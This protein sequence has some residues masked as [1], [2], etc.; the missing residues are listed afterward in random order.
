MKKKVGIVCTKTEQ[1][2][3]NS[4]YDPMLREL[5]GNFVSLDAQEPLFTTD[6][7]GL[8]EAYLGAFPDPES[9]QHHTCNACRR[10]VEAYGGLAIIVNGRVEP[11][12]WHSIVHPLYERPVA[13]MAGI[14]RKAKITGVFLTSKP[15]LGTPETGPWHHFALCV[16]SQRL[17]RAGVKTA[18]QA[19]AEKLEDYRNLSRALPEFSLA[20]L[21]AA[22]ALLESRALYRSDKVLGMAKWLLQLKIEQHAFAGKIRNNILWEA[23][24][25]APAGFCHPRSSMIGTLLEDIESGL[26]FED[27]SR[28][29]AEKMSPLQYQRPSADPSEGTIKAATVAFAQL[30]LES[31]LQR[32]HATVDDVTCWLWRPAKEPETKTRGVFDHLSKKNVKETVLRAPATIMTAVKFLETVAPNASAMEVLVPERGPFVALTTAVDPNAKPIIQWDRE[33][34]RNPVSWYLYASGSTARA[35]SL[36]PAGA[37]HPVVGL[38]PLPAHWTQK[39]PNFGPSMVVVIEGAR[40][41]WQPGL[42]LFPEVLM[43]DLK[44]YRGVIEAHSN[45]AK[46]VTIAAPNAAG[47]LFNSSTPA[48]PLRLR[49]RIDSLW[50]SF[51]IDR[52]D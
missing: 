15:V 11:A 37:Y 51:A 27:I 9:R 31:A 36:E 38:T 49:V 46:M 25:K 12:I 17:Y 33:N 47:L 43:A 21:R 1:I 40:D 19:M 44:P 5:Q 24:A 52:W 41:T 26:P 4:N 13:T 50:Q 28:K 48:T 16:P 6:A 39:S 3:D 22:C 2:P 35:F 7:G 29:F 20:T 34:C 42:A 10:F 23:V 14:V 8:W 45:S 30:G 32:R 18:S